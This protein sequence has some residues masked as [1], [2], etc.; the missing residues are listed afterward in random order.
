MP[1]CPASF[2]SLDEFIWSCIVVPQYKDPAFR[3]WWYI[4]YTHKVVNWVKHSSCLH[5]LSTLNPRVWQHIQSNNSTM[6]VKWPRHKLSN[7]GPI[8]LCVYALQNYS[9]FPYILWPPQPSFKISV[10]IV[11]T[12]WPIM[13]S[14]FFFCTVF[15]FTGKKFELYSNKSQNQ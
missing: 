15:K 10:R 14:F 11:E 2:H 5:L 1:P 4:E 3:V 9:I 8:I 7:F 12:Y 6:T 13:F